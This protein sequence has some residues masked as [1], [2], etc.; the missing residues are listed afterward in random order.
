MEVAVHQPPRLSG[1]M[2]AQFEQ[3][4]PGGIVA[5]HTD[6]AI[7]QVAHEVA[8]EVVL[9]P[10]VEGFV[11]AEFHLTEVRRRKRRGIDGMKLG[12]LGQGGFVERAARAPRF[13]AHGVE[14]HAAKILQPDQEILRIVCEDRRHVHAQFREAAGGGHKAGI[15]RPRERVGH[16]ND[17][18]RGGILKVN[19]EIMAV[20]SALEDGGEMR[21]RGPAGQGAARLVEQFGFVKHER[22]E[23]VG[24]GRNASSQVGAGY[25]V[26]FWRP[27]SFPVQISR[28]Q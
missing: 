14:I 23:C 12:G 8:Q 13:V 5:G 17:A 15:V 4:L 21:G 19:A 26:N 18:G 28:K 22:A 6:V 20:G 10:F 25:S 27:A 16:E 11:E 7:F 9:L 24:P 1:Q 2:G 3:G